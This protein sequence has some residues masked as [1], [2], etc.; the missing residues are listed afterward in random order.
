MTAADY[1]PTHGGYATYSHEELTHSY[2]SSQHIIPLRPCPMC[3]SEPN[4][5]DH[6]P[7]YGLWTAECPGC[8][9]TLGMPYGYG[10]RLDLCNDWNR[11]Y[12]LPTPNVDQS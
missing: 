1:R 8:G 4:F 3:G 5:V 12:L 2:P 6:H 9:L 11:E 7:P 10:S